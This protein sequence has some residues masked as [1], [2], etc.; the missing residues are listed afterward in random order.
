[1]IGSQLDWSVYEVRIDAGRVHRPAST[2]FIPDV[3]VFPVTYVT[4]H[5]RQDDVPEVYD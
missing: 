4:P 5:L 1:M 3:F 2:Y